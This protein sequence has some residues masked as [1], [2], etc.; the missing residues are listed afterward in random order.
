M[1][2]VEIDEGSGFC[3]GVV[4]AINEA[5]EELAKG[6]TLYC[7]GDI[8]HNSRE[9]ERLKTMGLIT[10]NR[11]EFKQLRNAKV[12]LRAHGEPPETYMIARENNIEIIDATCPVVLRLQKRIKQEFLQDAAND[13]KQIVIYGKNGHAEVLGLVGQTDGKAIVIEKA[14]EVKKLDLNKSVRLFSQTTKSLD[15]FQE[16]VAYIKQN[17]SPEATFEYYDTICRQVANRM[18]KLREFAATHDLI[19]FVSGKKSSNGKMLFEECLKVNANSHLID[20]EKEIDPSL[21]QNVQSIGVCGATSTP[22]WLME[23]IYSHIQSLIEESK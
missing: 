16:I 7:L 6:E 19:F 21:L 4:T 1:I 3:F 13:E 12:L 5:E 22:K 20:N 17:I 15:E 2:K 18:P 8:V 9:V 23:K 14:E 11:E 10:I